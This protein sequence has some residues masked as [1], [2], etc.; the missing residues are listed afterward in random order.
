MENPQS[1]NVMVGCWR[2]SN[3]IQHYGLA[4]EELLVIQLD[5]EK[6]K[7]GRNYWYHGDILGILSGT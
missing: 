6:K 3:W 1:M 7:Q 2:R 5:P 4:A